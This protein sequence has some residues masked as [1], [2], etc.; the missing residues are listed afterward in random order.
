MVTENADSAYVLARLDSLLR[1]VWDQLPADVPV[2]SDASF[3]SLGVDSLTLVLLL[4]KVGSEFHIDWET[5][6]SPGAASSL[7][8][9]SD[10]VVRRNSDNAA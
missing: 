6:T 5:E 10:L 2:Q 3:L 4:D 7:R 8:S 9:L 1:E